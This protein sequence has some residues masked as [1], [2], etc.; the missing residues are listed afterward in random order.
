MTQGFEALSARERIIVAL[1][2]DREEAFALADQLEGH[3]TWL[4]IGMTLFYAEGPAIVEELKS[5]GFQ[6]FLDLKFN[7]IPH[8]VKGAAYS[9]TLCGADML[10]MHA[11][12]A[13]PMMKAAQEG[14]VAAAQEKGTKVPATLGI[15]V[16]TSMDQDD[17]TSIG[18]ELPV[19][20]QVLR[21]AAL[22]DAAGI[23]GVVASP[24]E[25]A[26]LREK[27]GSEA[28]IVTPGVRPVGADKGDQSRVATPKQA[29][30]TGA[31]HIVIG[32]PITQADDP[33]Q[34]FE[35]IVK[36]IEA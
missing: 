22:T 29:L 4:K 15:T 19:A 28:Y 9:A 16:L 13:V 30:T 31:S 33:A 6:I 8:Q 25:A 35:D 5:R 14:A 24:Q 7:D 2:C 18:I 20:D 27:L 26:L 1:D 34:A 12:G 3:A 23:S 17:L 11:T 36:G 32:R 21:L 10:T